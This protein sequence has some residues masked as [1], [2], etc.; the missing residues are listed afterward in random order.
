MQANKNTKLKLIE[1]YMN[2]YLVMQKANNI[3]EEA[4]KSDFKKDKEVAKH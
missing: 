2:E 3:Y 1:Y 4:V